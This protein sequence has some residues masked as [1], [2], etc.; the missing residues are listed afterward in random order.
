MNQRNQQQQYQSIR[1]ISP[2]EVMQSQMTPAELQKTQVLNLKEVEATV[3]YEK[4][5][6]K[7]PAIFVA[8]LGI[9]SIIL[10]TTFQ[11]SSTVRSKPKVEKRDTVIT[12]PVEVNT[13]SDLKCEQIVKNNADGTDLAFL[14]TYNFDEDK[15]I[16]TTKEF[17][18]TV[19]PGSAVGAATVKDYVQ[20][21][22]SFI[23][24]IE[25]YGVTVEPFTDGF[26]VTTIV[27]YLKL[28]ITQ[29]NP[30]QQNHSSTKV[31]Y[32]VDTPKDKIMED[33]KNSGFTCEEQ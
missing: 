8:V 17:N 27:D 25:G 4:L 32:P 15:L 12:E 26:K 21:F 16:G 33:M 28:D 3:R 6:S 20:A 19:T 14:V 13:K 23:N 18:V 29:L 22:Q 10:G 1:Q 24:P 9:L 11:V 7:K 2:E 31:G 30:I 5:S